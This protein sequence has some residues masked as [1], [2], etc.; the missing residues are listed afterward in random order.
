MS[1]DPNSYFVNEVMTASPQRLRLMLI[2]GCLRYLQETKLHWEQNRFDLGGESIDRARA[3]VTE[4]ITSIN[5]EQ[6]LEVTTRLV[7]LYAYILKTLVEA[8]ITHEAKLIDDVVRVMLI[9]RDTWRLVC[10]T[11]A[12]QQMP[13]PHIPQSRPAAPIEMATDFSGG[14]S[15]EA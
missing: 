14:F 8:G 13:A 9:E 11:L 1:A 12:A 6:L 10:E 5:R 3:I 15:L 4:L 7:D 2:D